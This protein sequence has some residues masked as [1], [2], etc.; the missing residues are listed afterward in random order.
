MLYYPHSV[1]GPKVKSSDDEALGARDRTRG[2][3]GPDDS[4]RL[5]NVNDKNRVEFDVHLVAMSCARWE[6]PSALVLSVWELE[7][8]AIITPSRQVTQQ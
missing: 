2:F 1:D 8:G 5:V 7:S 6:G 4:A 3:R